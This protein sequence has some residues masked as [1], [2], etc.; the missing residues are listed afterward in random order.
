M[1]LL[2]N[3]QSSSYEIV[4]SCINK[5]PFKDSLKHYFSS[6]LGEDKVSLKHMFDF[7]KIFFAAFY[8]D[9]E[10]CEDVMEEVSLAGYLMYMS[11]MQ[12]DEFIDSVKTI[13]KKI[14]FSFN[15]SVLHEE[16]VRMLSR[17]FKYSS[18]FWKRWNENRSQLHDA[19]KQD[20]LFKIL[21]STKNLGEKEN[22]L[23]EY[24]KQMPAVSIREYLHLARGKSAVG[25]SA[26]DAAYLLSNS[27][28]A[29]QYKALLRS[30]DLFMT[31]INIMDDITDIEK[32]IENPQINSAHLLVADRVKSFSGA[33]KPI[34]IESV[35]DLKYYFYSTSC[36]LDLLNFVISCFDKATKIVE[37]YNAPDWNYFINKYKQGAMQMISVVYKQN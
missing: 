4:T 5:T 36:A 17:L 23:S 30:H 16:A 14:D 24:I 15:S 7:P 21:L 8:R 26:I 13:D 37:P 32:D 10:Q 31:A 12:Y 11:I 22:K 18:P 27:K 33:G 2:A 9:K 25:K 19:I 35:A 34:N 28:N 29:L 20:M 6:I 1:E 3:T